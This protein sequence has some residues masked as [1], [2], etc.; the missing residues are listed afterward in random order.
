MGQNAPGNGDIQY[1]KRELKL[2]TGLLSVFVSGTVMQVLDPTT[3]TRP[4]LLASYAKRQACMQEW[5][6]GRGDTSPPS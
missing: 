2:Q 3:L 6:E 4:G 1:T 5:G